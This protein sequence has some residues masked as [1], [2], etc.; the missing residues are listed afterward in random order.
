[1]KDKIITKDFQGFPVTIRF[2]KIRNHRV[3][4]AEAFVMIDDKKTGLRL[5][6]NSGRN[7]LSPVTV[8]K[9][10]DKDKGFI[11]FRDAV[12]DMIE[13][14]ITRYKEGKSAR[15]PIIGE[16]RTNPNDELEFIDWELK[17]IRETG[18]VE[19]GAEAV[20]RTEKG[21]EML[22]QNPASDGLRD[23]M[24]KLDSH[25]VSAGLSAQENEEDG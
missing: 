21:K 13:R 1:M 22:R 11:Y 25:I 9:L 12:F 14:K 16:R 19:K 18:D 5:D 4:V 8:D 7:V 17:R 15:M 6:G 24:R 23:E 3:T 10:S 20:L 2:F